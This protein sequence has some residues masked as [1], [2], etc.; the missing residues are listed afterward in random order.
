[1]K[2]KST[3]RE[4][5]APRGDKRYIRRDAKGRIKS[6]TMWQPTVSEQM[7][8]WRRE[9]WSNEAG[10]SQIERYA[11]PRMRHGTPLEPGNVGSK[12]GTTGAYFLDVAVSSS[13]L[14][15]TFWGLLEEYKVASAVAVEL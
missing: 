13:W 10:E 8:G 14:I 5:I 7:S 6:P 3:K 4:L 1:M 9:V 15:G 11:I 2:T 12:C